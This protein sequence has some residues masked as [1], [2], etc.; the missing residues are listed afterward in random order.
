[1]V[2]VPGFNELRKKVNPLPNPVQGSKL[3]VVVLR[4]DSP[5]PEV[6]R[7]ENQEKI[8]NPNIMMEPVFQQ[9]D[10]ALPEVF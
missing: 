7:P 8:S 4:T 1:M 3:P 2:T 6:I 5:S 9:T 10:P